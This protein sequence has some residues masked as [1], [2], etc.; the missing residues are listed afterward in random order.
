[1]VVRSVQRAGVEEKGV[2]RS[3][4]EVAVGPCPCQFRPEC[5]WETVSTRQSPADRHEMAPRP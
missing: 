1:M 5:E 2:D 3:F 4:G